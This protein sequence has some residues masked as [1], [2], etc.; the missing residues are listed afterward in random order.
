MCIRDRKGVISF[1]GSMEHNYH[2]KMSGNKK[3][4]L[5]HASKLRLD[6]SPQEE[7]DDPTFKTPTTH[8]ETTTERRITR[9]LAKLQA[10]PVHAKSF[11]P[12]PPGVG[13][14][15]MDLIHAFQAY[16][17]H[18]MAPP[19]FTLTIYPG[20]QTLSLIHI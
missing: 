4:K 10:A 2:V 20:Q 13:W 17:A 11:N 9:A 7:A 1:K 8:R 19:G 6:T 14:T 18:H 15:K 12:P 5:I 16:A 3:A